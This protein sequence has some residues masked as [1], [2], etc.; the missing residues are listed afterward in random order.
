[1]ATGGPWS[2]VPAGP[3]GLRRRQIDGWDYDVNAKHIR[4]D[5]AP[6]ESGL[7]AVVAERGLLPTPVRLPLGH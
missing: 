7:L 3:L 4:T 2:V 6:D 1:M 5:T